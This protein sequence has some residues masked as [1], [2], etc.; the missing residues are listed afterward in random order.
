MKYFDLSAEAKNNRNFFHHPACFPKQK[1][2]WN[3]PAPRIGSNHERNQA[4]AKS[5]TASEG[6]SKNAPTW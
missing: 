6:K 4:R 2:A 3:S 5:E 1:L